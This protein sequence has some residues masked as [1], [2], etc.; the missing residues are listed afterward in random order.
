MSVKISLPHQEVV[1]EVD[2]LA[3]DTFSSFGTVIENPD[4]SFVPL[5][6]RHELPPNA[7]RANQGS[8]LKYLD[9]TQMRNIYEHG[10]PSNKTAK[11][12]M[13]MFI[14]SPRS[15]LPPRRPH[16]D[17]LFPV[18]ILERHPYT[19]QTFIP[20]GL[21]KS[22]ADQARYLVIVTPSLDPS[23]ADEDFP[24]PS[25]IAGGDRLPGRGLPDLAKVKAFVAHGSQA[26]TYGAGTWQVTRL[27]LSMP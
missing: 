27:P 16:I 6:G 10:A 8:A 13:N 1:L 15:L 7:T 25:S 20:L 14:C 4:R 24:T 12:V 19:T 22:E 21:S 26:V 3:Q 11:A 23:P 9:V 2:P 18:E 5:P 17:G